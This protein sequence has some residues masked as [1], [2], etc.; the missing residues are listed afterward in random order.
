MIWFKLIKYYF[1]GRVHCFS[2]QVV[3][4]K[5]FLLNPEKNLVQIQFFV[6][7]KNAKIAPLIPKNDVLEP[8]A[9]FPPKP[10]TLAYSCVL[11]TPI[12]REQLRTHPRTSRVLIRVQL[13]THPRTVAYSSVYT[14]V[15]CRSILEFWGMIFNIYQSI[16]PFSTWKASSMAVTKFLF[17]FFGDTFFRPDM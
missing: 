9:P 3:M 10:C 13:R 7:E 1:K 16:K 12:F 17:F 4:I 14:V 2:M 8:N 11:N 5:C 15:Y 6:F